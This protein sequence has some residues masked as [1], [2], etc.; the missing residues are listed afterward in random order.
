MR[1]FKQGNWSNDDKCPVCNQGER[2][3]SQEVILVPIVGTKEGNICTAIQVHV[4]CIDLHY[5]QDINILAQ[6]LNT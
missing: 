6:Q 5:H 3:D 1:T 4:N 2:E